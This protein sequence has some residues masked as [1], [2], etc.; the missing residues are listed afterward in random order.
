MKE[1][2]YGVC[3]YRYK[4]DTVEILLLQPKGHTQWGYIKG[5]I[6]DG[7]SKK[8]CAVRECFEETG[9]KIDTT[10]L[11]HM[12][13]RVTK[14]KNI[15]IYLVEHTETDM[16]NIVLCEVEAERIEWFDLYSE[17][18][19]HKNQQLI[20]NDIREYFKEDD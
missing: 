15:G 4:N 8:E 1:H 20:T 5:K 9:I 10:S 17:I 13:Y 14:R 19:I 12:F 2:S 16:S 11:E 18:D 6:E 7:E 3:I